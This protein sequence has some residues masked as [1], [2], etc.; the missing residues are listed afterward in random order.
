MVS[1]QQVAFCGDERPPR[2]TTIVSARPVVPKRLGAVGISEGAV[3]WATASL[4]GA[5]VAIGGTLA[6]IIA[7]VPIALGAIV[8]GFVNTGGFV[9]PEGKVALR[10]AVIVHTGGAAVARGRRRR[11]FARP[12]G[13]GLTIIP[14]GI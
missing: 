5:P 14:A 4:R 11:C 13:I 12:P 8:I 6:A 2:P 10:H 3:L 9:N 7:V 1:L